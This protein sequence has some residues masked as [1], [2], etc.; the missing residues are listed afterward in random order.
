MKLE[1]P[2]LKPE[3][4]HPRRRI[5]AWAIGTGTLVVTAVALTAALALNGQFT[6]AHRPIPASATPG[7][8][9][10]AAPTPTPNPAAPAAMV[11]PPPAAPSSWSIVSSPNPFGSKYSQLQ[12]VTCVD[13]DDCWAVGD[14]PSASAINGLPLI[15]HN[16]GSGWSIVSSPDP[17]DS[18]YGELSGVTCTSADDCWAVG[19]YNGI[20]PIPPFTGNPSTLIEQYT[21]SGWSIASSPDPSGSTSSG[22]QAVTCTSADDCWAVGSYNGDATLI[23]HDAG[24]GWAVVSS[25]NP[26]GETTSELWAVTC[27]NAGDCWA[28][29]GSESTGTNSNRTLIEH[30]TG[31]GWSIVPNAGG[32]PLDSVSCVSA[33][34]CWAVGQSV[35]E[36]DTGGGWGI[37]PGPTPWGGP[38]GWDDSLSGVTCASAGDC[39]AVGD[40]VYATAGGHGYVYTLI[41]QDTGSGWTIV[42]SPNPPG[43]TDV[44]L[45]GVTCTSVGH[46][47]AVGY[48]VPPDGNDQTLIEQSSP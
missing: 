26:T 10:T 6:S 19:S 41:E 33:S 31:G 47:W 23:E 38:G 22:L 9:S 27:A 16:A 28:I 15:E 12:A 11:T 45:S 39:S 2:R 25:P 32:G 8:T 1:P 13:A 3:E 35:I 14:S 7:P 42:S 17:P 18:T 34:D 4:S 30:L 37:V 5:P 40:Q 24:S 36:R 44:T 29:G 48:S 20:Q 43:G 46:C 21:G